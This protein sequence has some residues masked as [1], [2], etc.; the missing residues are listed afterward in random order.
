MLPKGTTHYV[1]N[2]IDENNFLVSYPKMKDGREMK[3]SKEKHS[4][5]AL[6]PLK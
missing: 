1:I 3:K 6:K 5:G 4:D 2:L